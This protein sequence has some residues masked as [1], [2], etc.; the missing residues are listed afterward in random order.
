MQLEDGN[1]KMALAKPNATSLV[2]NNESK[3]EKIKK[4]KEWSNFSD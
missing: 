2:S 3:V 1:N 4:K